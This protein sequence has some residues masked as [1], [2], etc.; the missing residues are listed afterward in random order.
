MG[1][2]ELTKTFVFA[3]LCEAIQ[4]WLI[5]IYCMNQRFELIREHECLPSRAATRI[6]HDLKTMLR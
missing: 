6:N 1:A 3:A 4:E 5:R 2:H